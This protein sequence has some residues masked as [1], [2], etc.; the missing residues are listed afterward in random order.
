MARKEAAFLSNSFELTKQL[1]GQKR[2][3]RLICSKG[4]I[5]NHLK[6]TYS[7]TRRH[8]PLGSMSCTDNTTS[9]NSRLQSK[10]ALPE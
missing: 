7:D 8:Q 1:L 5:N 2:T 4:P 9:V 6:C 3:S 10:G